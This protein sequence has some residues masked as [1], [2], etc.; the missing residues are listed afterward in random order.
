MKEVEE[1]K[2]INGKLNN[3]LSETDTELN[4]FENKNQDLE[5]KIKYYSVEVSKLNF[6]K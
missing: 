6:H 2:E 4:K 1:Y 3:L 5:D